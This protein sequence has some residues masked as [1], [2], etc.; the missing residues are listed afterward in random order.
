MT[1]FRLTRLC[2]AAFLLCLGGSGC[3]PVGDSQLEEQKEPHYLAGKRLE[4]AMDYQGAIDS[5][6]KALEVNPHS[7]SAHFE[8][9]W[10]YE[11][12]TDNA[13]AI[14]HY[15]RCLKYGSNANSGQADLAK[16]RV[17]FC[18]Q[19]LAKTVS[20]PPIS[21]T[22]QRDL[23][24]VLLENR[25]LKEKLLQLQTAY[26]ASRAQPPTNPAPPI[27]IPTPRTPRPAPETVHVESPRPGSG[28]PIPSA[29]ISGNSRSTITASTRTHIV[30]SGESLASIA[31]KYG[32]S[33]PALQAANPQVRPSHM[34]VGQ[35]INLPAP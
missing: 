6:E 5:F 2:A 9:G 26:A 24:K 27:P 33:L 17:N 3:F 31:R 29:P 34:N 16:I 21:A 19:E 12:V 25:D 8:L 18:A 11:K 20:A 13:A 35:T 14:Y 1:C 4:N 23:E 32:L 7:A 30:K 22:T 28:S 15:Q 10:L